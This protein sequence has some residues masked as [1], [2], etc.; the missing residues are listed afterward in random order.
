MLEDGDNRDSADRECVIL[1]EQC[2]LQS[3]RAKPFECDLKKYLQRTGK[4][5]TVEKQERSQKVL[6]LLLLLVVV[7]V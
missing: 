1:R 2:S 5:V 4:Q 3:I 6:L 7:V